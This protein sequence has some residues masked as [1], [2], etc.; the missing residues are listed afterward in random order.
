MGMSTPTF[1]EWWIIYPRHVARAHAEKM[2]NRL[3][4]AEKCAAVEALPRHVAQWRR[5][6]R[7]PDK[8]P[9]AGTWLNPVNGRRWEDEIE[10]AP[11]LSRQDQAFAAPFM[12]VLAQRK[13]Q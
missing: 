5:E 4:D 12:Q 3:K 10:E 11:R 1:A 8:I 6:H 7:T 13:G 9:H 2:W